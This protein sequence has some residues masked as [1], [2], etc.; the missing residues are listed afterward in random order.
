MGLPS[1]K[2]KKGMTIPRDWFK[3]QDY[4]RAKKVKVFG[5]VLSCGKSWAT[6]VEKP[7]T[8]E[9]FIRMVT[10]RFA[11]MLRKAYPNRA[12][13][14]IL[15]DNEQVMH[16]PEAKAALKRCK[17]RVLPRWPAGSPDLNP[18]ENVWPWV[19]N[20]LRREGPEKESFAAFRARVLKHLKGLAQESC[21]DYIRSMPSRIE[22]AIERDGAM[23]TR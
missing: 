7:F 21:K 17:I 13:C 20:K 10:S 18:Q 3:K 1:E 23:G 15:I 16:T 19:E 2:Q 4:M 11:P 5:C 22:E 14:T 9:V 6:A 8:S 12:W